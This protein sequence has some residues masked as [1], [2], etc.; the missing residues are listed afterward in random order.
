[1]GKQQKKKGRSPSLS[2]AFSAVFLPELGRSWWRWIRSVYQFVLT[3]AR[4]LTRNMVTCYEIS[5]QCGMKAAYQYYD[6]SRLWG[7]L[8]PYAVLLAILFGAVPLLLAAAALAQP[9]PEHSTSILL[10][11]APG[12]CWGANL[13]PGY[14]GGADASGHY[15]APADLPGLAT[16]HLDSE[17]VYPVVRRGR[18]RGWTGLEVDVDGL[19]NILEAPNACVPQR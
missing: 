1:M 13:T 15:V 2:S 14:I 9:G 5:G 3:M 19:V 8:P 4:A 12:P 6:H 16:V 17:T 18:H 10:G 7:R 11:P